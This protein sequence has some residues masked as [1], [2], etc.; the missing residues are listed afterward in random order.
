MKRT[1]VEMYAVAL[2]SLS[3]MFLNIALT[4]WSKYGNVISSYWPDFLKSDEIY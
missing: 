4:P 1:L 3:L 2:C